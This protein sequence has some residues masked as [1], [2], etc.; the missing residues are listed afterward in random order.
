MGRKCEICT[1]Q[2]AEARV[3]KCPKCIGLTDLG[4]A[5]IA[6]L[7]IHAKLIP[8][9]RQR[10][11][12]RIEY[13]QNIKRFWCSRCNVPMSVPVCPVCKPKGKKNEQRKDRSILGKRN[14]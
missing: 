5:P 11:L 10:Y 7:K 9:R 8:S 1:D 6:I 3:D 13:L 12:D 14:G 4:H 2:F